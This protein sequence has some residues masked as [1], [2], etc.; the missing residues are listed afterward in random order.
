M[1]HIHEAILALNS[2]IVSIN[3]E[4]AYDV[5]GNEVAYDKAA[6]EVKLAEMQSEEATKQ[7]AASEKLA[8]LGLTAD[9]LKRILG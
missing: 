4:I 1:I 9:D 2:N 5:D 7:N 6:A 8:A 3:G